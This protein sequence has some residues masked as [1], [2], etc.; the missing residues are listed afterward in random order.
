MLW[1]FKIRP[2]LD[3]RSIVAKWSSEGL[4]CKALAEISWSHNFTTRK[5]SSPPVSPQLKDKYRKFRFKQNTS[6]FFFSAYFSMKAVCVT[7]SG[8]SE[9]TELSNE[10]CP[11][12]GK[13]SAEE[14]GTLRRM[15]SHSTFEDRFLL[16]EFLSYRL[17][18]PAVSTLQLPTSSG[19]ER[20]SSLLGYC[21]SC[22][23]F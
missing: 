9:F 16:A 18:F 15:M 13:T 4:L 21:S 23:N 20:I 17:R 8:A 3:P 12:L 19:Y 5:F 11:A 22:C 6:H 7:I 1:L 2:S 10:T 14:S